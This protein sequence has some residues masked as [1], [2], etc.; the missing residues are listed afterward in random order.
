MTHRS[1]RRFVVRSTH[2][3]GLAA[4][5]VAAI[6]V[7]Q[8]VP[9]QLPP[10]PPPQPGQLGPAPSPSPQPGGENNA[11]PTPG[12]TAPSPSPDMP[13]ADIRVQVHNILVPTTVFDPDGHGYVN[14]L[15]VSDFQVL[16]NGKPQRI[17]SEETEQPLSVVLAVQANSE[18]EPLLPEIKKSGTL[19][20]GLVVGQQGDV[21]ILA[22]DHRMQVLQT[23]TGDEQ[24]LDDAMYKV[25]AGS[26]SAALVDAVIRAD[27]MLRS[28]DPQNA[29][30]RVIILMSRNYDK[31]S[32]L[33]LDEA[34]HQIQFDNILVYC[35]DIS[36][37][38]TA[39]MKE[40]DYPRP[41]NGGV[42][43]EALGSITGQTQNQTTVIQQQD[44]NVLNAVPP[45]VH[46]IRDIFRK[47]DAEAFSYFTG[48]TLYSFSNKRAL[49][50]AITDIGKNLNSQYLLSYALSD[51]TRSEPGF[52]TIRVVVKRPGLRVLTRPGYW[53]GGG[54]S[55]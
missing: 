29:R 24:K 55:P 51:A 8:V 26:S 27:Q 47:S 19:L 28:H 44:G 45:L 49:E 54:Q 20:H 48:G 23:F 37:W 36:R 43:P 16:D 15:Q 21:A 14:G 11:S 13:H 6:A 42:P 35:V 30:R 31:G 10:G 18:V 33:K 17:A 12:A 38:K 40:P 5:L 53:L 7:G 4:L 2:V 41:A 39:F 34:I 52:H 22:F 46:S 50:T 25:T 32:Q 3:L 9:G 1:S